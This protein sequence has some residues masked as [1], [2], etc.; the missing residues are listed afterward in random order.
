MPVC[1]HL[2]PVSVGL[3]PMNVDLAPRSVGLGRVC[4]DLAPG[5]M[6]LGTRYGRSIY[7]GQV[8]IGLR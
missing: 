3:G 4:V 5:S 6:G 8:T 2:A 1:V 7:L